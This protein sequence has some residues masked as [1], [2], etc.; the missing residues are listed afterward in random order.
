MYR[1]PEV[2]LM[3]RKKLDFFPVK[4]RTYIVAYPRN[5]GYNT[6]H[7]YEKGIDCKNGIAIPY[8]R[9][10]SENLGMF[11]YFFPVWNIVIDG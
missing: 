11:R 6:T 8:R 3:N 9:I 5:S 2:Y 1:I 10:E 4:V 7:K